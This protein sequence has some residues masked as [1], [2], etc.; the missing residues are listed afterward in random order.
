[1]VAV[2]PGLDPSVPPTEKIGTLVK[3]KITIDNKTYEVDV[4]AARSERRQ[5]QG[6]GPGE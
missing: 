3:L 2:W 1:M 4:E 6:H 5:R